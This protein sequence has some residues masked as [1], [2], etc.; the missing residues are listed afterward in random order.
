MYDPAYFVFS[1]LFSMRNLHNP[2][3]TIPFSY[4]KNKMQSRQLLLYPKVYLSELQT[5]LNAITFPLAIPSS[6]G[7]ILQ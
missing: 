7:L 6:D 1:N 3:F 5:V 2:L 4:Q